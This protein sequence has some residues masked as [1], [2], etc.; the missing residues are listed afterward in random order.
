LE[1]VDDLLRELLDGLRGRGGDGNADKRGV[2]VREVEALDLASRDLG[3]G[4]SEGGGT[5]DPL[6]G[7]STSDELRDD[8]QLRG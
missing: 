2:R 6:E 4:P 7:G 1:G 8:V 3:S 5:R